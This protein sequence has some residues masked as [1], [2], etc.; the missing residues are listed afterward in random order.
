MNRSVVLHYHLFKNAGTSLDQ[1]LKAHL[2]D[3]W[4]TA[5]FSMAG[6]NN[7]DLVAEWIADTPDALAFS[8]HTMVGPLPEVEGVEIIPVILLRNPLARIASAYRFERKQ[9]ADT[10]GAELAKEHDLDG[11]VRARLA[12]PNDRQCRNF[13]VARLATLRPGPGRELFRATAG[14]NT[15]LGHG[16]VGRVEYFDAFRE[17]LMTR[18]APAFPDFDPPMARANT[19]KSD[20]EQ[21]SLDLATLLTEH[22]TDDIALLAQVNARLGL[23]PRLG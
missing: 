11:Y 20:S 14:L 1:M 23:A 13:Q 19:T 22:N 17:A 9:E 5:E 4:V 8:S 18:L 6:E 2:G 10:W 21:I 16:V 3:A 12:R 7:S 15:L